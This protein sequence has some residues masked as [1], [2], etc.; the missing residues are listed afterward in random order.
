MQ[1]LEVTISLTCSVVFST[2]DEVLLLPL[3]RLY[4]HCL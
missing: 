3:L 1:Y 4:F 2:L